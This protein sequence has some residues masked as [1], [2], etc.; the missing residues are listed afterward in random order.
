MPKSG[1]CLAPDW[2][3]WEEEEET[4]FSPQKAEKKMGQ[5]GARINAASGTLSIWR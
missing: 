5:G 4:A 2:K 3:A 1:I